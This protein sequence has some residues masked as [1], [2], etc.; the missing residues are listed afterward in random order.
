M[1]RKFPIEF[2]SRL[3]AGKINFFISLKSESF[4]QFEEKHLI[5]EQVRFHIEQLIVSVQVLYGKWIVV[6]CNIVNPIKQHNS[7][8]EIDS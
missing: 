8:S 7:E 4:G 3:F 5:N 1:A 2:K 6:L